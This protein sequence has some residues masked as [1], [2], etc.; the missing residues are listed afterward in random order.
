MKITG[1]IPTFVETQA[2][3]PKPAAEAPLDCIDT[4][5]PRV[6][7]AVPKDF[8]SGLRAALRS[9]TMFTCSKAAESAVGQTL[10]ALA[11]GETSLAGARLLLA[12]YQNETLQDVVAFHH[13]AIRDDLNEPERKRFDATC[14]ALML[15]PR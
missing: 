7:T 15:P 1:F 11:R 4:S 14:A 2:P 6:R 10:K 5:T 13:D 9:A 12:P 8:R 3:E